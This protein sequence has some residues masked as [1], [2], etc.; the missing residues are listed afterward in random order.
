M[1]KKIVGGKRN[2]GLRTGHEILDS[3]YWAQGKIQ[4]QALANTFWLVSQGLNMA[5]LL[6]SLEEY[7]LVTVSTDVWSINLQQ[8]QNPTPTLPPSSQY[9]GYD[10]SYKYQLYN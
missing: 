1:H 9:T 2:L 5:K 7:E 10:T 3:I 8:S 6:Y 4:W